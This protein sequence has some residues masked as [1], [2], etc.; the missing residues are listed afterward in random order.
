MKL[1]LDYFL[2][3][4]IGDTWKILLDITIYIEY[5]LCLLLKHISFIKGH[6][7]TGNLDY[8][9]TFWGKQ[10]YSL[11]RGVGVYELNPTLVY[12]HSHNA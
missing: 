2:S 8:Y 1:L 5:C 12:L 7:K 11:Q 4:N 3:S 9:I 6:N 10:S